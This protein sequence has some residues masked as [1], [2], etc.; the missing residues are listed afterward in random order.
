[1]AGT[2]E[3]AYERA[4]RL[5]PGV[6]VRRRDRAQPPGRGG[7]RRSARRSVRRGAASR[8]A[9]PTQALEILKAQAGDPHPAQRGAALRRSPESAT[10]GA[11]SA[12]SSSRMPTR[13]S[14]S[15]MRWRWS[16]AALQTSSV[17]ATSL[18]AWR[19]AKYVGSNA[20][21]IARD[22]ATIGIGAGQMSRVDAVRIAVEKAR[23]HG[24]DLQ[25]A[26]LAS[27][28]FF[29]FADGPRLALEAGVA[30]IIQPGGSKRDAEVDRGSRSRRAQRWSSPA[31]ATSVTD[32]RF[33]GGRHHRVRCQAP[34][35]AP[36]GCGVSGLVP[37]TNRGCG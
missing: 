2:I 26:A 31:A 32:T 29:P 15:A 21:V 27:D 13:T 10:T 20:I 12:A 9:S 1:M 34:D 5:R 8:R 7:A 30:A 6:R 24:H 18:L 23:R 4:L 36:H 28:A 25:G 17:G 11:Y 19:A 16:R 22:L 14:T 33:G 35:V 37:G 3:E